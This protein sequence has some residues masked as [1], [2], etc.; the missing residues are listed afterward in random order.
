[1]KDLVR[2]IS[3]VFNREGVRFIVVGALAQYEG[4]CAWRSR[5]KDHNT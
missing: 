2:D 4:C 1:M 3:R 5:C